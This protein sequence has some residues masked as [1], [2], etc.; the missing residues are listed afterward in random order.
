MF[1]GIVEEIGEVLNIYKGIKSSTINVK[2]KVILEN[3]SIG[4]SICTNGVCLTVTDFKNHMFVADVMPETMRKTNLG[5]L[6][7]GDKVNLERALTLNKRLG[8]HIVSGHID[9]IGV[10]DGIDKEDNAYWITVNCDRNI[11][12]YIIYKGSIT[13]D[14]VSLTVA[15]VDDEK[16]TV[17]IIPHTGKAT[18]LLNKSKGDYVNLECDILGKYVEKLM[19]FSHKENKKSSLDISFLKDNGFI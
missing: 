3:I 10:I 1:T 15:Y 5:S 18:I 4:D 7:P 11:L 8:G 12:K 6:K 2:C 19:N 13:I 17:S 9:G 16:F 14:G